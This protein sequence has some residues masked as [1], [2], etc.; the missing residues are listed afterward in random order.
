MV[1]LIDFMPPR[2]KA[3]D[4]VRLVRGISGT[5]EDADGNGDPLRLRRGHSLGQEKRGWRR[6]WRFAG[7]T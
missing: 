4:I 3:S 5:G 1:A 2:G 7:R 6:C